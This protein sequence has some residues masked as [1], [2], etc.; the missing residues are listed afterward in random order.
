[1]GFLEPHSPQLAAALHIAEPQ[2]LELRLQRGAGLETWD[3]TQRV[4]ILDLTFLEVSKNQRRLI[5]TQ[6]YKEP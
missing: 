6:H 5:S 3:L 2:L 1:M 4:L